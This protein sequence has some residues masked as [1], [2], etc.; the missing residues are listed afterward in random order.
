MAGPYC[1]ALSSRNDFPAYM[2]LLRD[3]T[4]GDFSLV[5]TCRAEVCG[6]LWGSGNPDISGVGMAVGYLLDSSISA[7]LICIYLWLRGTAGTKLGVTRLILRSAAST[8]FDNAIFFTFAIQV[9]SIVTLARANF[10]WCL[11]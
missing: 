11:P 7:S 1:N 6:A 5:N 2:A 10:G 9:A 8:F 4:D 3:I